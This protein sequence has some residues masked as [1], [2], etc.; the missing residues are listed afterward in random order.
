MGEARVF[1]SRPFAFDDSSSVATLAG[2]YC[3]ALSELDAVENA[4]RIAREWISSNNR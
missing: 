2:D 3:N 4:E 1:A